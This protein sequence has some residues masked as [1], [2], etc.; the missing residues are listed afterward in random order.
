MNKFIKIALC[1]IVVISVL[2]FVV[3]QSDNNTLRI[4]F[5]D[6]GQGD[7]MLIRTPSGQNIVIDGGPDNGFIAKLGQALPFYNQTIDLLIL[8]HPHDDHLLGLVEVTKRY[9]VKQI[10]YSGALHSTNA[11]LDWLNIIK[12]KKIPLKIAQAGQQ[13]FFND[14]ELKVIY[15][16]IN[17]T[18]QKVENLNQTSVVV[19]LIYHKTKV[20]FMADLEKE[21]ERE[22]VDKYQLN[23]RL[24][25][26]KSDVIKIGHHGS[27]Y[28]STLA[29]LKQIS[30]KYA[31][32][33]VGQGNKFNHP[34]SST[35]AK[36][37]ILGV[38]IFRTDLNGDII[39]KSNGRQ[40]LFTTSRP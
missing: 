12:E 4:Y 1:L 33:L 13:F 17:F 3:W 39:F 9:Q 11:Y 10:L 34:A 26:L 38:K 30:P 36:L 28:S 37:T 31:I 14:L 18:N 40:A 16:F 15:P 21:G 27:G 19:Q 23:S 7:G 20:L 22:I 2:F 6:I 29:F 25:D 32:I 24:A 5:F 8:T 35:L